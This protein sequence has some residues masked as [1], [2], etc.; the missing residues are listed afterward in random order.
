M[1]RENG[2]WYFRRPIPT[3]L[4]PY[5]RN[6]NRCCFTVSLKTQN[7][8]DARRMHHEHWM[9]SERVLKEAGALAEAHVPKFEAVSRSN[10]GRDGSSRVC[11]SPMKRRKVFPWR[12]VMIIA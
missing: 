11:A 9:E 10:D 6:G 7:L 2:L 12:M 8:H 3:K 1:G 4:Q 5:V